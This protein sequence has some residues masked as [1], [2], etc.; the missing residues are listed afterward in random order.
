MICPLP[1]LAKRFSGSL[2]CV[3]YD[4][5]KNLKCLVSRVAINIPISAFLK[6]A[7]EHRQ[8]YKFRFIHILTIYLP[9]SVISKYNTPSLSATLSIFLWNAASSITAALLHFPLNSSAL[10]SFGK[11]QEV[12]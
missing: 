8:E 10:D 7:I 1:F 2:E 12:S 6:E 11:I 5:Y 3:L 4:S 9:L